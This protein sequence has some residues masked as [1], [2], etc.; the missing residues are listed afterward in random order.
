M[1]TIGPGLQRFN[2]SSQSQ[3]Q[4]IIVV[5]GWGQWVFWKEIDAIYCYLVVV[6]DY[7]DFEKTINPSHIV[8]FFVL[9]WIFG[10]V[11]SDIGL[12]SDPTSHLNITSDP[13]C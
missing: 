11:I 13:T 9:F 3:S 8:P 6:I 10:H 12:I 7:I 4:V 5:T 1:E 2:F